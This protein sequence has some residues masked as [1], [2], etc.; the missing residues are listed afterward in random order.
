M[1]GFIE[2]KNIIKNYDWGT[3]DFIPKLLDIPNPEQAPFAE[4]W[5]GTHSQG[6]SCSV[7]DGLP[8]KAAIQKD[9]A[10]FL[11]DAFSEKSGELPFLFKVL[12]AKN[13]LSI[14]AH[15]NKAQA[16][17]G[18][19]YENKEGIALNAFER[20][21]K[22]D[23]HKPE[24]LCALT[25]FTAMCG[26]RP[27]QEIKKLLKIFSCH[28]TNDLGLLLSE[29]NKSS[30]K[31]FYALNY[32]VE[33]SSA[34][35]RDHIVKNL[36]KIKEKNPSYK[37][38]WELI[39]DFS[40]RFPLDMAVI[41][42][43]YLNIIELKPG[44]AI[45]LPAGILHAYV[46]GSGLELMSASD[47]VLRAGLTGKYIDKLELLRILRFESFLPQLLLPPKAE[48]SS[49]ADFYSYK[50]PV[51]DFKLSC[52]HNFSGELPVKGPLIIIVIQGVLTFT[53]GQNDKSTLEK[54]KSAFIAAGLTGVLLNGTYTAY[55]AGLGE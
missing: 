14:Q 29:N 5:M 3:E 16:E 6:E 42:P 34:S 45:F 28:L 4:L 19:D 15:P 12:S 30:L 36:G 50:T 26:F 9:S 53:F 32:A 13:S 52:L 49:G 17:A 20:N 35:L 22:D 24:I 23:N 38:V 33:K 1:K 18:F 7:E 55:I 40:E 31:E 21:Y 46:K 27:V 44:E 47:N 39:E 8:L 43:L 41:S 10:F 48:K 54:G 2:L 37:K 11:G 25:D 51:S